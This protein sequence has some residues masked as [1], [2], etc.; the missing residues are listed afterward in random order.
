MITDLDFVTTT[1]I[2]RFQTNRRP[3]VFKDRLGGI[4]SLGYA[5]QRENPYSASSHQAGSK[6]Q[7]FGT[8]RELKRHLA[9]AA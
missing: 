6:V 3:L 8:L 4:H 7:R 9:E 5:P 2:D 1:A